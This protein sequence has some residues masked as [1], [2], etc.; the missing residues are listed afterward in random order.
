MVQ[1]NGLDVF[2]NICR[3]QA[4]ILEEHILENMQLVMG[5]LP[6]RDKAVP[7]DVQVLQ[8]ERLAKVTRKKITYL[9]SKGDRVP[10][11]LVIPHGIEKPRPA[12][13]CLHGTSGPRGRTA[14]LGPDYPRYTLELAERGYVTIAPDYPLLGDNQTDPASLGY[15]SGSAGV[16]SVWTTAAARIV[17]TRA[18]PNAAGLGGNRRSCADLRGSRGLRPLLLVLAHLDSNLPATDTTIASRW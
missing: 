5:P 18:N 2:V 14:G 11:Y 9:A 7:L 10:A 17:L 8:S 1:K 16:V 3:V 13:L 15:A 6:T 4:K 12:V